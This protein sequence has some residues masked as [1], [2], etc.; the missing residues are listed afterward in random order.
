MRAGHTSLKASLN[1]FNIVSMAE[2]GYGLQTE[3]HIFWDYKLYEEQRATMM[4]ILSE[5]RKKEYRVSYRALKA[6]GKKICARRLLLHKQNFNIYLKI[7][8]SI[9]SDLS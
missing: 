9:L 8:K 1:R 2:C 4:A 6:R 5:N 3:E 7:L